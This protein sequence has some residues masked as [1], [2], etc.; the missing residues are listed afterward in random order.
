MMVAPPELCPGCDAFRSI[1]A[2][3]RCTTRDCGYVYD[4][5]PVP[6]PPAVWP[7][8]AERARAKPI[9]A[10]IRQ[11]LRRDLPSPCA[12]CG[13]EPASLLGRIVYHDGRPG[14]VCAHCDDELAEAEEDCHE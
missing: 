9:I 10:S 5:H 11:G 4:P 3:G 1:G 12:N 7:S 14:R 13:Q 6:T 8:N 2:D